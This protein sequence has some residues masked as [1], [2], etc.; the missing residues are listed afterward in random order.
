MKNQAICLPYFINVIQIRIWTILPLTN[1]VEGLTWWSCFNIDISYKLLVLNK[2]C[3]CIA[4]SV[5]GRQMTARKG[6]F[7]NWVELVGIDLFYS[8][9]SA[10]VKIIRI[11][12][13]RASSLGVWLDPYWRSVD[14]LILTTLFS[15][16]NSL[17]PY[18][19]I[20]EIHKDKWNVYIWFSISK[21]I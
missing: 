8:S 1:L 19:G 12:F 10:I 16:I 17:I 7:E 18:F 5:Q 2:L 11:I 13:S 21:L 6:F 15:I 14:R 4:H 20:S 9:C 3:S